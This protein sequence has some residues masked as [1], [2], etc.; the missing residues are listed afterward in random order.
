MSLNI[1]DMRN[2]MNHRLI[3][4]L[5]SSHKINFIGLQETR[6]IKMGM[7]KAKGVWDNHHFDFVCV[8]AQKHQVVLCLFGL[9]YLCEA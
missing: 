9:T 4:N 1:Y 7:F 6:L 2:S 5:C 8:T 3:L